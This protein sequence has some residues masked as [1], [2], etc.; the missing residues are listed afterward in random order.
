MSQ[1]TAPSTRTI[2]IAFVAAGA[3]MAAIGATITN[4]MVATVLPPFG[5]ALVAAGLVA[6]VLGSD[7][8]PTSSIA[9]GGLLIAGG[10]IA[11]TAGTATGHTQVIA[12]LP[13]IGAAIA[14]AG[15]VAITN[16][17]HAH[18]ARTQAQ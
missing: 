17:A 16:G 4:A 13:V 14:T 3:A 8:D 12:A 10:V 11:A 5:A 2:G 9:M 1:H 7:L 15:I 18:Q 6:V